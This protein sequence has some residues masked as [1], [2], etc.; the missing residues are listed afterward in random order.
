MNLKKSLRNKIINYLIQIVKMK[1]NIKLL[2]VICLLS[3]SLFSQKKILPLDKWQ[4]IQADSSRAMWGNYDQ[5]E[6]LRYYGLD[7]MDINKDGYKDLVSGRYFYMNPG[8]NMEGI[9]QRS[10]LGLNV[11]AC[12]FV[13]ID[14]DE[15]ADAI[16]MAYPNI[17]WLETTS[18]QG[19]SWTSRVIG[20]VPKTDHVNGQGFRHARLTKNGK[21]ELIFSAETGLFVATIP[22]EPNV[23]TNWKFNRIA[24]S[25]SDEGIGLG[26]ID[27]DGD[28]DIALG[29]APQK[30]DVPNI[31]NWF[32]NPGN[33]DGEWKKT[34]IGTTVNNIDRIEI[35]DFD[36]DG[37]ID[38][39]ISE[40]LYPGLE[41]V[42]HLYT[43]KNP[44]KVG[45]WERKIHFKGYSNNNLDVA[46][47]DQDGD[48][49]IVTGEHKG[50]IYPTLIFE[51]DGKGNFTQRVL[52]NGH[53]SHLG[54]QLTDLDNDGDLDM[55]SVAWDNHRF[56]HVWRNDAISKAKKSKNTSIKTRKSFKK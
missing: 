6:W 13:D 8:K 14:G 22:T 1:E 32:E 18:P 45:N 17:Y 33:I 26:D 9:W 3:N 5:P 50:K 29:D 49:D 30:G 53:E 12:M 20:K 21:E 34:T 11:D 10:D 28:L 47:L 35:A 16:G 44:G 40:E 38:I 48:I 37:K 39:A 43:F 41:P 31:L 46:D 15:F 27:G 42:A 23:L 56:L 55:A 54:T 7:F 52:D 19:N 51:N 25:F 4:Y 24:K 36:G 2:L